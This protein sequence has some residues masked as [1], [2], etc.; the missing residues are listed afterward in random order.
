VSPRVVVVGSGI[1]GLA[2][3][4][5]LTDAGAA[6]TVLD[7][8]EHPGGRIRTMAFAG[9]PVETGP[10]AFLARVPHAADLCRR[11]GLDL[12][13]PATGRAFLWARGGLR[14]LP[15]GLVLGVPSDLPA[16]ARSGLLSPTGLARAALDLVLPRSS[17]AA[18]PSVGDI[19][20]A[21][22]GPAVQTGLVDPLLGGIHA[23]DSDLLSAESTSPQLAAAARSGRSLVL[24]LRR[25]ARQ[26]PAVDGPVFL[27]HPGG[28]GAV[29]EA[30]VGTLRAAGTEVAL[31]RPVQ[32]LRRQGSSWVAE[33]GPDVAA[34][35][36]VLTTPAPVTASLLGPHAPEAAAALGEIEH[37]SV[38]VTTLAY[39]RA[40]VR[41]PLDGS[42]FLVP[43]PEGR[44][45]TASTWLSSKWAH[46]HH[47]ELALIRVSAGRNGDGRAMA[48][49]D[50]ELIGALHSE[51]S[52]AVGLGS[53][54]VE[55]AVTRWPDAFAQYGRGHGARLQRVETA[56]ASV[57]GLEVA[58]SALRGVGLP[59]CIAQGQA[60][61]GRVLEALGVA[62]AAG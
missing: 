27:T 58:G 38:V 17:F 50:S 52:E 33:A 34:D 2:A 15:A 54:P 59:A 5:A 4:L 62:A 41:H 61:A 14:P 21:R 48:M 30:L 23:G 28:L 19:V 46:L 25:H 8:A 6:V 1:T 45:M 39:D 11:L 40:S 16:V 56:L 9:L 29:V 10:D 31:G 22:L 53:S 24:T 47:P 51:L 44:L 43:R 35:A 3:A 26:A 12:V 7:G 49:T 13:A 57:A 36:V 55:A 18:D 37:S 60:A 42:G 20:R 32:R